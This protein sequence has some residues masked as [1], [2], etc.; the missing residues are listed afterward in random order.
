MAV[1]AGAEGFWGVGERGEEK[2]AVEDFEEKDED[3]DAEGG[4]GVVSYVRGLEV[5][6]RIR[7]FEYRV[8]P[9]DRQY[10][11]HRYLNF[12]KL[13]EGYVHRLRG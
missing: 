4:L 7:R 13:L 12:D 3:G 6:V 8:L 10:N 5:T 1:V 11:G 2:G 9:Q